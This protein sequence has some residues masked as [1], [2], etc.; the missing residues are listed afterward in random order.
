M[1]LK[2]VIFGKKE[3]TS[4]L[5]DRRTRDSTKKLAGD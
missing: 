5:R 3:A 1:V 4:R 2:T